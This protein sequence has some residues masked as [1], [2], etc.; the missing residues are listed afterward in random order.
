MKN[1]F[2]RSEAALHEIIAIS[3]N[4]D[5]KLSKKEL[6]NF[7]QF[8]HEKTNIINSIKVKGFNPIIS[9]KINSFSEKIHAFYASVNGQA[10]IAIHVKNMLSELSH[11]RALDF[12]LN[13]TLQESEKNC[14][15]GKY[16]EALN[17]IIRFLNDKRG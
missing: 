9:K 2:K 16:A 4:E 10:Q 6:E 13:L 15:D 8:I 12:Q 11:Q 14:L 7:N 17:S 3:K 1:K 5:I